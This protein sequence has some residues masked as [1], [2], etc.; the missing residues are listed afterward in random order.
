ML[1]QAA[2]DTAS[3]SMLDKLAI[4]TGGQLIR[5]SILVIAGIPLL[6]TLSQTVRMWVARNSTP[7]RG[8]IAGK[9]LQYVGVSVLVVMALDELGFSLAPLLGAAGVLG[10]ALGFASQT[11]VSNVISGF[12]LMAEQPFVVDDVIQVGTTTGRVLSIDMM[13]VKLRTFDNRFVRIPNEAIVKSEVTNMTRFPIRRVDTVVGVAYRE[14]LSIVRQALLD[15]AVANP[16]ALRDPEPQVIFLRYAESAVEL[17]FAVWT[18]RENYG[19][20]RDTLF[21]EVKR[22]FDQGGIELA[23][24]HRTLYIGADTPPLPVRMVDA[25]PSPPPSTPAL[26]NRA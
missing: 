19:P 23:F 21:E 3:V 25:P 17:T 22:R 10:I 6:Y 14:D 2:A 16:L 18:T 9:L 12:F 7:Q 13:S 15:V 1:L 24:P 20:L 11:S 8:M 5:A 4:V 26:E